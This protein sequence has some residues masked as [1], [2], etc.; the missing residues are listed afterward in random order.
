MKIKYTKLKT[1]IFVATT[2]ILLTA[3]CS[4]NDT[5]TTEPFV[6]HTG[7]TG[8]VTDIDGNVYAT[9][10]IGSQIWMAENL[11]VTC[12]RNGDEIPN[13][14]DNTLWSYTIEGAYCSY[15]NDPNLAAVFGMLYNWYA[16]IDSRNIAPAGW[17]VPTEAE[18]DKLIEWLGGE[19]VA[20][21][22]L[23]AATLWNAPNAG[24]T[25]SSGF[26]A[27][28]G[29]MKLGS[30][31]IN[32]NSQGI[33]RTKSAWSLA[34]QVWPVNY[35]LYSDSTNVLPYSLN[36]KTMGISVRCVKD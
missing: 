8:T 34:G 13:L 1:F 33:F 15:N 30:Y 11:K 28:P 24:A 27:L 9:I 3:G 14:T 36:D 26:H 21:G 19:D 35:T 20:G 31:F 23:K 2:V 29:G 25:D 6:D 18:W 5:S 22:K 12:Y 4:N 16:V 17:H 32:L 10:G 7:E